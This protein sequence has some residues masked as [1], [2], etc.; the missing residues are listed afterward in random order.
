MICTSPAQAQ[1]LLPRDFA[2]GQMALPARD[3]AAYRISLP[4]TV[5]Q[6]TAYETLADLRVFN[7]EGIVVPFSVSR[8]AAQAAI[9]KAPTSLPLFPLHEGARVVFDG[10]QLTINSAG[11]AVNLKT[12]NG[13]AVEGTVRQYL[14]DARMLDATLSALQLGWPDG[15]RQNTRVA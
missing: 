5:Y 4:L 8:P 1:V 12:Q 2:Y 11:S 3:A 6:Y 9:H 13:T 7:A 15:A 10:V 14:L